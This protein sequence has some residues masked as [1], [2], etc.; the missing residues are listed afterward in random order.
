M[1]GWRAYLRLEPSGW[2]VLLETE[3]SLSWILTFHII[4][5]DSSKGFKSWSGF[6]FTAALDQSYIGKPTVDVEQKKIN[7]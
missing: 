7:Y 4:F 6:M 5:V 3:T 2:R 1:G